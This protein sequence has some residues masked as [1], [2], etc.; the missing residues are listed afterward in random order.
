[1]NKIL[2]CHPEEG[3]RESLKA[4]LSDHYEMI[5]VESSA[6]CRECLS[7]AK[8]VRLLILDN[9]EEIEKIKEE[10]PNVK[11]LIVCRYKDTKKAAEALRLGAK[12]YIVEPFKSADVLKLAQKYMP[13]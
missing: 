11:I 6:Q 5:L 2:I 10:R 1:M 13:H 4:I 3:A 12:D 7:N 9:M 8:D